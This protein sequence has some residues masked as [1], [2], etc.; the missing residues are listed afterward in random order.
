MKQI[1]LFGWFLLGV[2][3]GG[4]SETQ[5]DAGT[6]NPCIK[7][8]SV[9]EGLF[10]NKNGCLHA[11]TAG[12]CFSPSTS[13]PTDCPPPYNY[14]DSNNHCA[15]QK[16][17]G[18]C[19]SDAD[20]LTGSLTY[21]CTKGFCTLAPGS[22]PV[23]QIWFATDPI[24]PGVVA[25]CNDS[26]CSNSNGYIYNIMAKGY[27]SL[28]DWCMSQAQQ[29]TLP[30][31]RK[32]GSWTALIIAQPDNGVGGYSG[33]SL[34]GTYRFNALL[35]LTLPAPPSYVFP[36]G[37]SPF[38]ASNNVIDDKNKQPSSAA[39]NSWSGINRTFCQA[40][41]DPSCGGFSVAL[42]CQDY[43]ASFN[44]SCGGLN[45][46]TLGVGT[47]EIGPLCSINDGNT[48]VSG[49][50]WNSY[51]GS[52]QGAVFILNPSGCQY[53]FDFADDC[54]QVNNQYNGG[55]GT[56]YNANGGQQKPILCLANQL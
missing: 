42:T 19:I 1:L 45:S 7:C 24:R 28:D 23:S 12:T 43:G 51:Q 5:S 8:L 39:G 4:G 6:E 21:K 13:N 11:L 30:S 48:V 37:N 18:S 54:N 9:S 56:L 50:S 38:S 16:V 14:C 17:A 15:I 53:G 34:S 10:C 47:V 40:L 35:G 32:I 2:S 29:S 31:M 25:D 36:G 26:N 55:I 20:C 49:N 3:C 52:D 33:L 44:Y 27:A 46:Y 22:T 41:V